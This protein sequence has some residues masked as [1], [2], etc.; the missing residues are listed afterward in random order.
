MAVKAWQGLG[1]G[2]WHTVEKQR[3]WH[4]RTGGKIDV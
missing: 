3:Q 4:D 1:T 2:G